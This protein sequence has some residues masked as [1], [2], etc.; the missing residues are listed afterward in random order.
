MNG[1]RRQL[2]DT[3]FLT[4]IISYDVIVFSET[5][6]TEGV[7]PNIN[8][9]I[10]VHLPSKKTKNKGRPSGGLAVMSDSAIPVVWKS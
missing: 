10:C 9:F 1:L 4:F 7:E 6:C 8:G 3:D 2:Q 5:W